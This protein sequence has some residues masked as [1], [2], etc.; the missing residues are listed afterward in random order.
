MNAILALVAFIGVI[1]VWNVA[2]KRNIGE[3]MVLGFLASAAFG[4]ADAPRV[5]WDSLVAGLQSE[6][7]FAAL[8]FVFV[9]ELL[10][11]TGLV[12][13][14][15]DILSSLLGRRRG[16]SAYAATV[17]SGLFGAVAH[18]GA[19]IVATVGSLAIPWMKRSRASGE[20]AALVLSGNAG[21]GATFPF[22]GA[23]FV[24]LA[25]P[26]VL[27]VL[28]S[29]DVVGTL[30]VTGAWMVA[31]RLV[32]AYAIVRWRGV[33]TMAAQDIRPL[34]ASFGA[35]WTSLLVLAAVA[36]PVLLTSG[37]VGDWATDRLGGL[38]TTDA[39]PLL[40]W[41]PVVMLVAGLLVERRTLPHGGGAWWRLLGEV[42]P[43]L[44]LVGVTMVS[45]FAASEVLD[46]LGLGAE[47]TPYLEDLR[48]VPPLVAALVVGLILVIVAGP[49]NT[50]STLAAVGPVAFAALTASGVPA[51][52]AFAAVIV[53]ASSEGCSPPGAAPLYVAAGI[54][55]IDPV[56]IFLP[57]ALYYLVPTYVFGVLIATGVLWIPG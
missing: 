2:F 24:L 31:M 9:S 25:A 15:I 52:V 36:V 21:V 34:R 26:T 56:R 46:R 11:R 1:I 30:F 50:T 51:H 54:A 55:D 57:V 5:A 13:R 28:S 4:G 33:G 12:H 17:A 27:P 18:N 22:S 45:A 35:G 8:A 44:G 16:G 42:G 38:D 10:T 20:T 19:A 7:T 23:F 6:I 47:L 32:V 41:L 48:D 40:V 53:W 3:A 29:S 49:L 43:Q 37:P 14:M 39:V